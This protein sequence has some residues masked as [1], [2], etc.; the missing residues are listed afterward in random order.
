MRVH[1]HGEKEMRCFYCSTHTILRISCRIMLSVQ[2]YYTE[3][4]ICETS[5]T[6]SSF[7]YPCVFCW[8]EFVRTQ[9]R[10][11]F[12]LQTCLWQ[13]DSKIIC[14]YKTQAEHKHAMHL[15]VVT[16]QIKYLQSGMSVIGFFF[17]FTQ[18]YSLSLIIWNTK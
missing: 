13:N 7:M 3:V 14:D 10:N 15:L 12:I 1:T 18:N 5:V 17:L 8:R 2:N 11:A 6:R 16:Q 9:F 4:R